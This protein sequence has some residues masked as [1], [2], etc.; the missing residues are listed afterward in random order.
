MIEYLHARCVEDGDCWIWKLACSSNGTPKM[1]LMIDGERKQ[2]AARRVMAESLGMEIEG[3]LVTSK[4][5][6]PRCIC[7]DHVLVVTKSQL[8]K[9]I[10]KNTGF[11][12]RIE[13]RKKI[14]DSAR[15]MRGKLSTEAA[16]EIRNSD[17]PLWKLA[18]KHGV[19]K[20]TVQKVRVYRAWQDYH[21]PFAGLL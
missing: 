7:P 1:T 10:A 16:T 15:K 13:R 8:G 9:L 19:A 12:Q 3:K 21:S 6:N 20:S 14:S 18:E 4:C 11:Q 17:E 2:K 5:G